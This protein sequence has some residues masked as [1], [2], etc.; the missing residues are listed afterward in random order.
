MKNRK[1]GLIGGMG[2]Y[3][4]AYF[5]KLLLDKAA[6]DFGAKNNDEFPEILLDSIPVLDFIADTVRLGEAKRMLV[7]RVKILTKNTGVVAMVC[8]TGH[9]LAKDLS[10]A[11]GGKFV[12]MIDLVAKEA[13]G[14]GYK[15]VGVLTTRVTRETGLYVRSL[16]KFGIE[17][18]NING[19]IE[20]AHEQIIREVIAGKLDQAHGQKLYQMAE[21]F[22]VENELDGIILGCTE[23]PL[24]FPKD[25]FKNVID[26]L[27]VLADE[28]LVRYY[29]GRTYGK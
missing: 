9:I 12:S 6:M 15:R 17:S 3:A 5:Y 21:K 20:K 18:V 29:Q 16:E 25:K 27:D 14:R 22:V 2:P 11:S 19:K 10:K 1:I 4:S 8:N 13:K 23:L 7:E 28:L 26:C 24:V